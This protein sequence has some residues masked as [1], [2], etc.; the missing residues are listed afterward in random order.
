MWHIGAYF[1]QTNEYIVYGGEDLSFYS[2]FFIINLTNLT[3]SIISGS[4]PL[5]IRSRVAYTSDPVSGNLYVHGGSD[6]SG[7]SSSTTLQIHFSWRIQ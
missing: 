2:D 7:I 1:S 5:G 3:C 4:G 6:S